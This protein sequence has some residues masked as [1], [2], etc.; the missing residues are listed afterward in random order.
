MKMAVW[1]WR[2]W[3]REKET[4]FWENYAKP[5]CADS[6]GENTTPE[7]FMSLAYETTDIFFPKKAPDLN[8]IKLDDDDVDNISKEFIYFHIWT[9]LNTYRK[10]GIF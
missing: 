1:L 9:Y 10:K 6:F 5:F 2:S 4:A 7:N 3:Q 8:N